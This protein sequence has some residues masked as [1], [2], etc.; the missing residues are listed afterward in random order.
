MTAVGS[1]RILERSP[2]GL[3]DDEAF[4]AAAGAVAERPAR[5]GAP[6]LRDRLADYFRSGQNASDRELAVLF[7]ASVGSISVYRCQLK[8]LGIGVASPAGTRIVAATKRDRRSGGTKPG[9]PA[10]RGSANLSSAA[11]VRAKGGSSSRGG[12]QAASLRA[13]TGSLSLV[14]IDQVLMQN[15]ETELSLIVERYPELARAVANIQQTVRLLLKLHR[16]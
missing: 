14:E 5:T 6:S 1:K 11:P 16:A 13:D 15:L 4:A 7:G 12:A 8:K 9:R 3:S 10:K 2:K